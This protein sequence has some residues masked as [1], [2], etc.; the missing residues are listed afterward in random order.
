M[1]NRRVVHHAAH[2]LIICHGHIGHSSAKEKLPSVC[3]SASNQQ[4][5]SDG[6][7]IGHN[8]WFQRTPG[9]AVMCGLADVRLYRQTYV[10]RPE[11]TTPESNLFSISTPNSKIV[12]SNPTPHC[13]LQAPERRLCTRH[14]PAAKPRLFHPPEQPCQ[15]VGD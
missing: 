2:P 5:S 4:R 9:M 11:R 10:A 13:R 8:G 7:G 3:R 12:A 1:L 15:L 6:R 14:Q